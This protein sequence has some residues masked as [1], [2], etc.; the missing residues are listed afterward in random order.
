MNRGLAIA[1]SISVGLALSC[2]SDGGG[3][4]FSPSNPPTGK[5]GA[6]GCACTPEGDPN[7]CSGSI[8][9][10]NGEW[11][12]R[13]DGPCTPAD[14][15]IRTFDAGTGGA[16][17]SNSAD[18]CTLVANLTFT[19]TQMNECGLAAPGQ[20][21]SCYWTLVFKDNGAER[22][23]DWHF[24]D[25]VKTLTYQC[26]GLKISAWTQGLSGEPVY[27]GATYDPTTRTLHW[28]HVDYVASSADAAIGV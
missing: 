9:C 13:V 16:V 11:Q 24:S 8:V 21:S 19:A 1:F 5:P 10:A 6:R 22:D 23:V 25:M 28:D 14:G 26:D 15:G 3:D 17:D 2:S 4:C 20:V 18:A 12:V 27:I 7:V